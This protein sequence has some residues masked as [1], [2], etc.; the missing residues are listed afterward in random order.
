VWDSTS[1]NVGQFAGMPTSAPYVNASIARGTGH[2]IGHHILGHA[3]HLRQ[4]AFAEECV[5]WARCNTS[6]LQSTC[7]ATRLL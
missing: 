7:C 3:L 6:I 1:A 5:Q 2:S 4:L